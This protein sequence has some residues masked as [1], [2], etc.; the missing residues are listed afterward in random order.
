VP[1]TRK[2]RLRSLDEQYGTFSIV[3]HASGGAGPAGSGLAVPAQ[4]HEVDP[5]GR[6][7]DRGGRVTGLH[8]E[9]AT[10]DLV[11]SAK[12]GAP[13]RGVMS[14]AFHMAGRVVSVSTW[15]CST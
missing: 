9:P 14:R 13:R 1:R 7:S 12:L 3:E 4:D 2:R 5:V 8:M 11:A 10:V 6:G 15:M